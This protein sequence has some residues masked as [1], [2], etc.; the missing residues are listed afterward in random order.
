DSEWRDEGLAALLGAPFSYAFASAGAIARLF[1]RPGPVLARWDE[2]TTMRRVVGV[3]AAD[4]H[5]RIGLSSGEPD[6][7]W[8]A[9][10]VPSYAALFSTFSITVGTSG[11]SGDAQTDARAILDALRDGHVYSSID[12]LAAPAVMSFRAV[13][14][15]QQYEQGSV[16]PRG[17]HDVALV[18]ESN[19]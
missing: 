14:G 6:D 7:P 12:A 17:G 15:T 10:H 5:A 9:L 13:T 16:V 8:L 4:A 1:D 19:A 18:V 2:L 3:A 11:L